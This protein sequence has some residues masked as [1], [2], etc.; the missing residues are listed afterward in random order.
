M[1]LY[2]YGSHPLQTIKVYHHN[3]SNKK[4][5][6]FIHGGA[7]RDPANTFDDFDTMTSYIK[8]KQDINMIGI[9]YRLS[10]EIK[11]PYHLIDVV[12]ALNYIL[13]HFDSGEILLV[14]H[15]VG[16]TL[17]LQLLNYKALVE[18]G[19]RYDKKNDVKVDLSRI[20][21]SSIF[22]LD[23]IYDN[24]EL[25]KEYGSGYEEF[26]ANA[27]VSKEQYA[28][29]TQLS[30]KI[31]TWDTPFELLPSKFIITQSLQDELLSM[32]QTELLVDYFKHRR[33]EYQL[34]TGNWGLH[35][36]MYRREEVAD[37]IIANV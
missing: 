8:G 2:S 24:V 12:D 32:K 10:P 7:W 11:H 23:G 28:E 27:F 17:V 14:G 36:E 16:A 34:F 18:I 31:L 22:L 33:T 15:S 26:V 20:N 13:D 37:L 21:V 4:T 3:A 6:V 25:V 35:E 19:F 9:N 5:I 1:T 30:S 29:A